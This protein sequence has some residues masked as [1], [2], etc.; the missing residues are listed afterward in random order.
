M[1][2]ENKSKKSKNSTGKKTA[3]FGGSFDPPHFGHVNLVKSVAQIIKPDRT[4][5]IPAGNAPHKTTATPFQDRFE[6]AQAAF[7]N[8]PGCEISDI[9]QK[10]NLSYTI[11]TLR[12]LKSL[13]PGDEFFLIIGS[14]MLLGFE[15][16]KDCKGI[17]EL[18][19]V[20]AAARDESRTYDEYAKCA[21]RFG[22]QL[23]DI[24]VKKVSSTEIR[25]KF[26]K[27]GGDRYI[28][29]IN[30]A[31]MCFELSQKYRLT[32]DESE[33]AY[34][35]ALLHDIMKES[36]AGELQKMVA[37]SGFSVDE[38]ELDAPKLWHGIAGAMYLR[39]SLG[40]TDE[41]IINA[42]RFHTVGRDK[43]S[44]VEKAVYIAD[45][46]SI[47]RNSKK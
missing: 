3:I 14:D 44:V 42:V 43:M 36:S 22:V 39:D 35:A 8:C 30:T 2:F 26:G 21:E 28:H 7:V 20:V 47:E 33:K 6:L 4:L 17:L 12:E 46:I 31:K 5:I 25:G 27:S 15:R 32:P 19:T 10:L 23:L 29:S 45:K 24:P 41:D 1:N 16:W 18:C 13:Y 9:E 38:A 40:I 37:E 11:D 34:T